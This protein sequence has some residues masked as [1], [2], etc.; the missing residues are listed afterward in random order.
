MHGETMKFNFLYLCG[1][2]FK[3]IHN[4]SFAE[5]ITFRTHL[6]ENTLRLRYK[7]RANNAVQGN[8]I[9]LF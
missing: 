1:K 3:S 4:N 8:N 2:Y 9:F 6:I 7:D 5:M